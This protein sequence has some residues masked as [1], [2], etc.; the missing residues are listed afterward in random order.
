M[1]HQSFCHSYRSFP[2]LTAATMAAC[3][4]IPQE[5]VRFRQT[6]EAVASCLST[7]SSRPLS[8][9]SACRVRSNVLRLSLVYCHSSL[10]FFSLVFPQQCIIATT[11]S[12]HSHGPYGSLSAL[13][14]ST[15]YEFFSR[16]L[17]NDCKRLTL[18]GSCLTVCA[19]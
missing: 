6:K 3:V 1:R 12:Y 4:A 15:P 10:S 16:R 9:H 13:L 7:H 11:H 2:E 18:A 8:Q 17:L 14:D 19:N 5:T